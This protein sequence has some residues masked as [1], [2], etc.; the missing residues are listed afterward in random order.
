MPATSAGEGD[1]LVR[2]AH[3]APLPPGRVLVH[4]V[5]KHLIENSV[6]SHRCVALIYVIH[7]IN[8]MCGVP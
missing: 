7:H 8:F 2:E 3:S 6:E 4:D 5:T 1:E